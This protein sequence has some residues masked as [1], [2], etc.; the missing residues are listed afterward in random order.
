MSL[1]KHEVYEEYRQF[2]TDNKFEPLCVADFG[3]AMKSIFPRVKPRRLGQRGNSKY[4]YSGLRKRHTIEPPELPVLDTSGCS[5]DFDR[6]SDVEFGNAIGEG[7]VQDKK[8]EDQDVKLAACHLIIEWAHKLLGCHFDSII[9]LG[10]HLVDS[11]FVDE[12]S[13]AAYTVISSSMN[14]S[15]NNNNN[16]NNNQSNSCFEEK[17]SNSPRIH[18]QRKLQEKEK[19]K[20]QKKKLEQ[21]KSPSNKFNQN[22]INF[23]NNKNKKNKRNSISKIAL[24]QDT[25]D[26]SNV[27]NDNVIVKKEPQTEPELSPVQQVL[28]GQHLQLVHNTR[29]QNNKV[30]SVD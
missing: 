7:D 19:I 10:K 9:D 1:P 4:C 8:G 29:P 14:S 2:C 24:S 11:K 17:N 22:G 21:I 27:I 16:N 5:Y 20:E 3:K 6:K 26:N 13:V 18:L 12:G 15:N 23:P 25:N 28:Q 30:I